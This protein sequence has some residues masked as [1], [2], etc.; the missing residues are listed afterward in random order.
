MLSAPRAVS[1]WRIFAALVVL[2][3]V[4]LSFAASG[5]PLSAV[6]VGFVYGGLLAIGIAVLVFAV[7]GARGTY[8]RSQ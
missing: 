1:E 8:A 4:A 7:R 2:L 3:Y 5:D 6:A